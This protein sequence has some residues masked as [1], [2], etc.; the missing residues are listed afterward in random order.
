VNNVGFG[1]GRG[2]SY[3]SRQALI[4]SFGLDV[5]RTLIVVSSPGRS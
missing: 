5:T 1:G 3:V 4:A 2:S